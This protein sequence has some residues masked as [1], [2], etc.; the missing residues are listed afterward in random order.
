M[1]PIRTF[2][3]A[4]PQGEQGT[5]AITCALGTLGLNTWLLIRT[6]PPS[7]EYDGREYSSIAARAAADENPAPSANGNP[8]FALKNYSE[9]KGYLERLESAGMIR[10]T[11]RKIPQ[12]FVQLEMV[13]VLVPKEELI[14]ICG[15]CG[16]WEEVDQPRFSRCMRCKSKHYCSK[17]CQKNDWTTHKGLCKEG[18][19][20]AEVS[21][22]QQARERTAAQSALED[23]GFRTIGSNQ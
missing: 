13:E 19:T 9:N 6:T 11:G 10:H 2:D 20:E 5:R 12:G 3:L 8:I 1:A 22:A 17:D 21:A 15:G 16:V 4:L 23:M 7:D 14:K 18:M